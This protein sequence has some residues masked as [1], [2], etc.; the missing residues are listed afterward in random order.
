MAIRLSQAFGGSAQSWITQQT[1]HELA[2]IP[3]SNFRHQISPVSI[4]LKSEVAKLRSE[5]AE[6]GG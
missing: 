3:H 6:N 4:R 5:L 1:Q 2:Q